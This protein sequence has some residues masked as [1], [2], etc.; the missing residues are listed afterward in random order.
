M[1]MYAKRG[2]A[3]GF[4]IVELLIVVIVIAILATITIVSFNGI[5]NR[6]KVSAVQAASKQLGTKV[7]TYAAE[8]SEQYPGDLETVG[9]R[10][11]GG[12]TYQYRVNNSASPRT[13]CATSTASNISYYISNTASSPTVGACSGHAVDGGSTLTNLVVNPRGIG[14]A[15]TVGVRRDWDSQWSGSASATSQWSTSGGVVRKT[16]DS[17]AVS[18]WDV[19]FGPRISVTPG[20]V[21]SAKMTHRVVAAPAGLSGT[22]SLVLRFDFRNASNQNVGI[23]D[24]GART[25]SAISV[26]NSFDLTAAN[27]T[28]PT[29]ASIARLYAYTVGPAPT[30]P[31][32]GTIIEVSRPMVTATSTVQNYADGNSAGWIWNGTEDDSTSTGR[33]L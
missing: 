20:T 19:W 13:F 28:V 25:W 27:V 4:T 3:S 5:Q 12:V 1:G 24:G 29:G 23:S 16:W 22:G 10:E 17:T 7:L 31:A 11:S 6:A 14:V 33:P 30:P 9:I 18:N 8:N 26:G 32:N 2:Q 21:L 15:G